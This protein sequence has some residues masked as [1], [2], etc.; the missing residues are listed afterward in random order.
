MIV[1]NELRTAGIRIALDDFGTGF[2]SLSQLANIPFDKIKIDRSFVSSFEAN[3]KQAKIVKSI[4]GLGQGLGVETTAEGIESESQ[5]EHLKRLGCEYGQGYLFGK[6]MPA[7]SVLSFISGG[8]QT[9][10]DAE[11]EKAIG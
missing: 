10:S 9:R 5:Y 8:P 4:V 2:S 11:N 7:E 1:I 6:A 3:E